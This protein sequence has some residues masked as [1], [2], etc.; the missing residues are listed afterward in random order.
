MIDLQRLSERAWSGCRPGHRARPG[1]V[2]WT[3]CTTCTPWC[4]RRLV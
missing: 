4:R 2:R 3:Q 1:G